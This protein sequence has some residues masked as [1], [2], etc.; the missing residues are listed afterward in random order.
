MSYN[1][2]LAAARYTATRVC[3][4]T[5]DVV[6]YQIGPQAF[7]DLHYS[8]YQILATLNAAI[9]AASTTAAIGAAISTFNTDL[10]DFASANSFTAPIP[11]DPTGL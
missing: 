11:V 3:A 7:S 5:Y 1:I 4:A 2:D 10:A 8:C 9:T 6:A